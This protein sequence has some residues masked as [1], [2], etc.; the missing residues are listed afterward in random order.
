MA[1]FDRSAFERRESIP[2]DHHRRCSRPDP[3][4]DQAMQATQ[5]GC[6]LI[7]AAAT[8]VDRI[9]S[10]YPAR[11]NTKSFKTFIKSFRADSSIGDAVQ[12]YEPAA[13]GPDGEG[14]FD[15]LH[16]ADTDSEKCCHKP[17]NCKIRLT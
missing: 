7:T 15:P 17:G 12:I 2:A 1:R 6:R 9:F 16:Q 8:G 3:T 13:V 5:A 10:L 11:M 4:P 14:R